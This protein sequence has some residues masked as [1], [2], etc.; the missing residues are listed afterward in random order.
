MSPEQ[1]S[2]KIGKSVGEKL[3]AARIAQHYTQ[4]NLAA[5]DFSVSYISAIERGQIH[6]SL[7]ALEILAARL[8]MSSTQLLPSKAQQEERTSITT[9]LSEREEDEI[10]LELLNA[11]IQILQGEATE[12]IALLEQVATHRLKRQHQLQQRYLLGQA[13]YRTGQYQ[14][15]EYTLSEAVQIAKELNMQYLNLHILHQLAMTYAAMRNY[16]Q[17]LLAHQRCL[18]LLEESDIKDPFFLAQIYIQMGQHYTRLN[19][20]DQA[21]EMFHKALAIT[22]KLATSQQVQAVYANLSHYHAEAKDNELATL[23]AYKS[24]QLHNQEEMT[25][26]RS[27]LYHYLGHAIM[28]IDVQQARIYLDEAL[29]NQKNLQDT[30]THASL[31]TRNADWYYTQHDYEQAQ[32]YAQ[33]GYDLLASFG[34]LIIAADTLIVLGRIEYACQN[35][36]E[37]SQH[38][39]AGLDMLERLGSHEELANESVHYAELLE[40]IGKEHEAFTHFRRAFQSRQKLGK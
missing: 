1:P 14:E 17:A 30:L 5:P 12:A 33:Q 3:R 4:S 23:Y 19:T 21:L 15:S 8:G 9:A 24:V 34:D 35:Y 39:V 10:V 11:Q 32:T 40:A 18:N 29:Q 6:P 16:S 27:E 28:Q 26:L 2:S 31:L 22:E 38:F 7:R 13:Y 25:Q 37:G 36:D 20:I